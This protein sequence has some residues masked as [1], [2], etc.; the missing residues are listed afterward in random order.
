MHKILYTLKASNTW[1]A[2]CIAETDLQN[3]LHKESSEDD[4]KTKM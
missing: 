2:I 1:N 3:T 4:L